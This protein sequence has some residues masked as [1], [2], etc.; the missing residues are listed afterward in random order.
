M[1]EV[2]AK[3]RLDFPALTGNILRRTN[4][5]PL[6]DPPSVR[7]YRD[8]GRRAIKRVNFTSVPPAE[9]PLG[10][11]STDP[12]LLPLCIVFA[13]FLFL[14]FHFNLY[15]V[16]VRYDRVAWYCFFFGS[17]CFGLE[18]WLEAIEA[19][20]KCVRKQKKRSKKW[21]NKNKTRKKHAGRRRERERERD[22]V[23]SRHR[24]A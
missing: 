10:A 24:R 18:I 12:L 2:K 8:I 22:N 1:K 23:M 16:L 15:F 11:A 4:D 14:S 6:Q 3:K 21:Y 20:E 17:L 9:Q 5:T 7:Q 19:L 13:F